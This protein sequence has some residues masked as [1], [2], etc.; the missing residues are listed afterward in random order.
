MNRMLARFHTTATAKPARRIALLTALLATLPAAVVSQAQVQEAPAQQRPSPINMPTPPLLPLPQKMLTLG[1]CQCLGEQKTLDLSTGSSNGWSVVSSLTPAIA[2]VPATILTSPHPAWN[3]PT[4]GAQWVSAGASGATGLP[5]A[6]YTYR[7]RFKVQKCTIPQTV[8]LTGIAGA[9]DM[10]K[11]F[12]DSNPTP[13]SACSGGWCFN[14]QNPTPS[15]TVNNLAPGSH[16]LTV[17]V[18]NT[19][20]PTGMFLKTGLEG[21]CSKE[22]IKSDRAVEYSDK[23]TDN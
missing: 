15:F 7:L 21:Q 8:K 1:C 18:V 20:G 13:I 10:F 4:G 12:L 11:V 2:A 17:V 22:P 5:A 3:L 6:T 9:D 14:T 16:V 23:A 19:G